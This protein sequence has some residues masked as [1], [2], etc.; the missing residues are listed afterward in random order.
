[1]S[2]SAQIRRALVQKLESLQRAGV[3]CVPRPDMTTTAAVAAPPAPPAAGSTSTTVSESPPERSPAAPAAPRQVPAQPVKAP[4]APRPVSPALQ[5]V[6]S[7]ESF[8]QTLPPNE[9]AGALQVL[10]D[11]VA[12]CEKCS[13]LAESRKQTVFGV[14][15]PNARLCFFGEAPGADEDRMG[16]PFVGKAGQLLT[17]IIEACKMTRDD[18][19][20]MNVLRCRPPGNRNPT[21]DE[22]TNCR[23]FFEKQ[24]E[25]IRPEFVCCL[26]SIAATTLLET[27]ASVGK[28]R[29]RFHDWRG[30]KV[31]VTYHPAYLL[32]N[33]PAKKHVWADMKMLM[34]EMGVEL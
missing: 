19:Y 8:G 28:L 29:G 3:R 11:E 4:P 22:A 15:N 24:F 14:G 27:T 13:P 34:K 6:G 21:P 1:M 9:R 17:K 7:K 18:V 33:A 10:A 23:P 2:D 16:E 32:R 12:A 30:M 25:I 20:I 31:V 26:G 5:T